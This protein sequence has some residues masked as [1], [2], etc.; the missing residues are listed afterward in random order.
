MRMSR[1]IAYLGSLATAGFLCHVGS[2]VAHHSAAMFDHER[3]VTL[4]GVVKEFQYVN[5][6]VWLI[7][8]VTKEDGSVQTW[9][10]EGNHRAGM[11]RAGI[12][13]NDL[14][15]GTKVTVTANPM[16]D[17]RPAGTWVTVV[18]EDGT[19]FDPRVGAEEAATSQYR[20]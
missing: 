1:R 12:F 20:E 3:T 4:E 10:F 13:M 7:V 6:H 2:A 5:P 16:K 14:S 18:R 17:G 8:D 19:V 15:P 9:G 11:I